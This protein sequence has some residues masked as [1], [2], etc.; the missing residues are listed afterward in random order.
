VQSAAQELLFD[1]G[2]ARDGGRSIAAG[3]DGQDGDHKDAAE[4]MPSIDG[5]AGIGQSVK[6]LG[7]V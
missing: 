6:L 7:H 2:P 1:P 4:R 5:R 3:E